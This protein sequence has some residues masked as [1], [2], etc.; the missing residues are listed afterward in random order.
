MKNCQGMQSLLSLNLFVRV[1][2]VSL[3]TLGCHETDPGCCGSPLWLSRFS[4]PGSVSIYGSGSGP[5]R[6]AVLRVAKKPAPLLY[7]YIYIHTVY[8]CMIKGSLEVKLPRIWT[9]GKAEVVRVREEKEREERRCRCAKRSES[10]D[11]LCFSNDL[12]LRRVEK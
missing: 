9:D 1:I 8:D 11:S 3:V 12:W 7:I 4:L 10:C 2:S 6:Y 5:I